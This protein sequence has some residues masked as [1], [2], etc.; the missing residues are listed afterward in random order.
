MP[1]AT[2]VGISCKDYGLGGEGG[3]QVNRLGVEEAMYVALW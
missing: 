2:G 3:G 1:L